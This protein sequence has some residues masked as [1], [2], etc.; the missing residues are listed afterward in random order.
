MGESELPKLEFRFD[1]FGACA[2]VDGGDMEYDSLP[3]SDSLME[4]LR[5]LCDEYDN[6]I[7]WSDPG[8]SEGW[9]KKQEEA[10]NRRAAIAGK[11]LQEELQGKYTVINCFEDWL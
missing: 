6:R 7:N 3:V 5:A 9:T 11:R 8:S 10:F 1:Y 2:W 4:E